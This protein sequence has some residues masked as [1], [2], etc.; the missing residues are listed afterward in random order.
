MTRITQRNWILKLGIV[1][2]LAAQLL[3]ATH[4]AQFGAAPHEHEG[5]ICI[6]IQTNESDELVSS[7]KFKA[8]SFNPLLVDT[9]R[10][11]EKVFIGCSRTT[12]PPPTGPPFL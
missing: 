11:F 10:T 9:F 3:S 6:A 4:A 5:V 8:P 2:F 7:S 1:L 12:L